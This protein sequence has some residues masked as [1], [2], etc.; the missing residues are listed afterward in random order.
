MNYGL[1]VLIIALVA[2]MLYKRFVPVKGLRNLNLTQFKSEYQ[3]H[4][5]VDVRE[6]Q[7]FKQGHIAG[8]VN[9]PLSQIERRLNEMPKDKPVYLYC[10]SG[11][12]SKQAA[13]LLS[14]HGYNQISQLNGGIS[15][16]DDPTTKK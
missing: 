7:E 16:W 1:Y 8:A 10:R 13:K 14:R 5:L 6:A 2:W 9:I 12:R 11:M 3:G 4:R 15:V